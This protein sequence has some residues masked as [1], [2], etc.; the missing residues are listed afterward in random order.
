MT[1]QTYGDIVQDVER[2]LAGNGGPEATVKRRHCVL[3]MAHAL[4][5]WSALRKADSPFRMRD[6]G[7]ALTITQGRVIAADAELEVNVE[8]NGINIGTV[9]FSPNGAY[10]S[11]KSNKELRWK[12]SRDQND[13]K[14]IKDCI[15]QYSGDTTQ[16]ERTIQYQ[17]FKVLDKKGK[18]E[19]LRNLRPIMIAGCMMEFPAGVAASA[20]IKPGK[21]TVDLLVRGRREFPGFLVFELK[22]PGDVDPY[23]TLK[24]AI[25]YAA[26][27]NVLANVDAELR[28]KYREVF[29]VKGSAPLRFGSVAVIEDSEEHREKIPGALE[30]LKV[31]EGAAVH[32]LL[33][34][35][36]L[37]PLTLKTFSWACCQEKKVH[38]T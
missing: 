1:P 11:P 26:G 32:V 2:A 24:Q 15:A 34:K 16:P 20:G 14:K 29:E 31:P 28:K 38:S 18:P 37:N 6:R 10:F 30:A 23:E 21:G 8:V 19:A 36:Q 13:A 22:S 5:G 33:Y 9:S 12:W 4:T 35:T 3:E 17:L 25:R 7:V 27:L